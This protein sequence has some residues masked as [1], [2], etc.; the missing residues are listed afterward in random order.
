MTRSIVLSTC[1]SI[2]EAHEIAGDLVQ[3]RLAACVNIVP[4]TSFYRWKGKVMK[5]RECLLIIKT[6]SKIFSKLRRR[7][8]AL[9]SYEVPEIVSLKIDRG[10]QPY[11]AWMDGELL[12]EV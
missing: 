12:S 10:S 2:R 6:D 9:H 11:L 7:I 1:G 8:L 5:E 3:W 4:V